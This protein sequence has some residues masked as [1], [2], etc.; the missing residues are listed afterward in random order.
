MIANVRKH[1]GGYL[2][3]IAS[4]VFVLVGLGAAPAGAVI[5][6]TCGANLCRI[7]S[8]GSNRVQLTTDGQPGTSMVYGGPSLSRNGTKLA[9]VFNNQ[10]IVSNAN[11]TGRGTPFASTAFVALMRPDGGQVA[12]IE[13]TFS[14]VP[15]QVCTYNLD[16]TGRNCPYGTSSA[17]WAPDNN[18]L[19]SVSAGAPN[20]EREICHEPQNNPP[21]AD[22]PAHN[23]YD[24]AVSPNGST[25]AVTVADGSAVSGHIA[26][27]NYATGQFERNLTMGTADEHPTWSADGKEVAFQRGNQIYVIGAAA[28]PGS[29]HLLTTGTEPTWG[30]PDVLPPISISVT[31]PSAVSRSKLL[32]HGL[33]VGIKSNQPVAAGV[34]IAVNAATARRLGVG[35]SETNLGQVVGAVTS[36]K[37]FTVMVKRK[38]RKKLGKAKHSFTLDLV[39]LVENAARQKA[40]RVYAVHVKT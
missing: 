33:A 11:A 26:L 12:E 5:V 36:S 31:H 21:C 22:D 30:G 35:Q 9:F 38:Y 1:A 6:Y 13:E 29:E 2:G 28:A 8:N 14:T 4:F 10:V 23:L 24:P 27:Y 39:V 34:E 32:S 15:F 20:F 7:N 16:G 37:T 25:L 3:L 40:T 19:I 18:L 17:G